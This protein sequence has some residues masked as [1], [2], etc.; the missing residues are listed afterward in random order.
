MVYRYE[1]DMIIN[2]GLVAYIPKEV[3]EITGVETDTWQ[4][5]DNAED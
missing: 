5:E 1:E 4:T 2:I 3:T